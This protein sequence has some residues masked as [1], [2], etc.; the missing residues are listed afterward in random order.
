MTFKQ[1]SVKLFNHQILSIKDMEE[2]ENKRKVVY[3]HV[4]SNESQPELRDRLSY[5]SPFKNAGKYTINTNFSI[6]GNDPGSGKT[7]ITLGLIAGDITDYNIQKEYYNLTTDDYE[8]RNIFSRDENNEYYTK[9]YKKN[10]YGDNNLIIKY[11]TR[12]RYVNCNLIIVPQGGVFRQWRETIE[13]QTT[14]RAKF[15]ETRKDMFGLLEPEGSINMAEN[16]KRLCDL[17]ETDKTQVLLVSSSFYCKFCDEYGVINEN[18]YWHRV[19]V[20][21][22]DSIR[23]PDMRCVKYRFAWF[24]TAT[25][26]SLRIPRNN[27]LIKNIFKNYSLDLMKKFVIEKNDEYYTE[28]FRDVNKT[29]TIYKCIPPIS[30]ISRISNFISHSVLEMIN[31]NNFN[32]AIRE[33]GGRTGTGEEIID[34]LTKNI[35]RKLKRSE[36]ERQY[37]S[38]NQFISDR[39]KVERLK[40]SDEEIQRYK[41][42]LSSITERVSNLD[43]KECGICTC[44]YTDPI[45]LACTHVFCSNCVFQWIQVRS[46]SYRRGSTPCPLCKTPIDLRLMAKITK[47]KQ[48]QEEEKKEE[49]NIPMGKDETILKII[50]DNPNG[51]FIIFSNHHESFDSF[52]RLLSSDRQIK[53]RCKRLKGNSNTMSKTLRDFASGKVDVILL[54]SQHN[55]AGIDLPTATDVILYHKMRKD[56]EKQ[57]IG[58]AL[59]I[60]RPKE[61]PL[62]VHKLF[63]DNERL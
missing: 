27:G 42:Q 32:G 20:D 11:D 29:E 7:L 40:K 22:A 44:E 54:N 39:D 51:K 49:V 13:K 52:D 14:L 59:R 56:L 62:R 43:S 58:R 25:W 15:I 26:E 63:Y 23:C 47:V 61:L 1:I 53:K 34:V 35:R 36:Y 17:L 4:I 37:I 28:L 9:K 55:G 38:N 50:R 16:A 3:N 2:R 48:S 18:L 6:L 60:G 19:I 33:L 41:S 46:R 57:V 5:L 21:E 30:Y 31:A 12:I 10:I 24:V 45:C 8:I